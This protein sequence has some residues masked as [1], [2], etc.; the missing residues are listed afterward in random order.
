M[1]IFGIFIVALTGYL[2]G[3][4]PFAVIIA[5]IC[6]VDIFKA[7]SGNPGATNVKRTCGKTAGNICFFLDAF[8]GFLASSV[9]FWAPYLGV[10]FSDAQY[11]PY[12]GFASALAGHIFPIF[13]KFRGGKGVATAI[14]GFC[15]LMFY[16][17]LIAAA[18]WVLVFYASRYVSLAS[19]ALSATL[20]IAAGFLYGWQDVRFWVALAV[21]I[22]IIYRHKSNISRLIAGKENK[23]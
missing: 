6:R 7:G 14:G 3:S 1:D 15:A 17:I 21:G 11:L 23:F 8:K 12:V 10:T 9:V 20:P 16:A 13:T 22:F 2:L 18:V 5:K 4:I 19:I